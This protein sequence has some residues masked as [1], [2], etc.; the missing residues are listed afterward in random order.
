MTAPDA[1]SNV[2]DPQGFTETDVNWLIASDPEIT[3]IINAGTMKTDAS[4]D[5]T[6]KID[7]SGLNPATTYYYAFGA[8]GKTSII[9]RMRTAPLN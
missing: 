3:D 4:C 1:R 9:G 7:A 5:G 6:I 8:F 2:P